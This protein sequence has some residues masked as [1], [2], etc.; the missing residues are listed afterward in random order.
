LDEAILQGNS[1]LIES[2]LAGKAFLTKLKEYRSQHQ[3][4]ITVVYIFLTSP[5]MCRKRI[6]TRI[7]KGGHDV[8]FVE[9]QR[10]FGRSIHNFWHYYR[11]EAD[12]WQLIYN[13][14]GIFQEVARQQNSDFYMLDDTLFVTFE[15]I[16]NNY[17]QEK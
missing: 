14:E 2:T 8:P 9:I 4:Y 6:E 10:R 12:Q 11:Q 7:R 1:L 3:Y 5:E 17:G 15:E 16:R 13:G